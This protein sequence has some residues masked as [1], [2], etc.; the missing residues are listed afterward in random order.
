M[1]NDLSLAPKKRRLWGEEWIFQQDNAAIH[2][3]S[4]IKKYLLEQKTKLLDHSTCS[5][6][7]LWVLII[8]KN[9]EGDQQY[10]AIS[11]LKNAILDTW[12]KISSVQLQKLS[13]I[14]EVIK[15]NGRSTKY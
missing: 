3:A 2:N 5:P 11:G 1:L 13:R 12:E 8:E 10:S 9:Y 14:F 7:N 15:A 4:M 6:E